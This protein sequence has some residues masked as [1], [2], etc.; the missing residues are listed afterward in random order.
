MSQLKSIRITDP[1]VIRRVEEEQRRTKEK[2]AA[3]T[4][5]RMILERAMQGQQAQQAARA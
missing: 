4:A 5:I 2:T 1:Y 3:K